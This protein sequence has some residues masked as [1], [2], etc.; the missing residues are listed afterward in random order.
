MHLNIAQVKPH[1][2][3]MASEE[4]RDDHGGPQSDRR[5]SAEKMGCPEGRVRIPESGKAETQTQ[6]S[7]KGQHSRCIEK[8]VG[9]E[10]GWE[11]VGQ[12]RAADR[13]NDASV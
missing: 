12:S 7:G 8:E 1:S 11:G 6:R 3:L 13:F 2:D 9:G 5:R 4:T 10:E